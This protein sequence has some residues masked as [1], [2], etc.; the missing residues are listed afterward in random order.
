MQ[1]E[2][3]FQL[4]FV[5]KAKG[6]KGELVILLESD[7]PDYYA[8]LEALFFEIKGQLI[9]FL[10]QEIYIQG[11]RAF[12]FLEDIDTLDKASPL[13]GALVYLPLSA[14]PPLPEGG[15]FLHDL[16]GFLVTDTE[17][18]LIG[19]VTAIYEGQQD[20]IGVAYEGREVLIPL[21]DALLKEV[22]LEQ[23]EIW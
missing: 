2:A 3:C 6:L 19:P 21:V 10:I 11:D 12:V 16:V 8:S 20:L 9:P 1:K 14:L 5:Q 17:K 15:Y 4:G 18:G 13:V 22:R 7:E 23:R